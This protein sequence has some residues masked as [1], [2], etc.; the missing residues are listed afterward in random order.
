MNSKV[1]SAA[2]RWR[3]IRDQVLSASRAIEEEDALDEL[4]SHQQEVLRELTSS[5]SIDLSEVLEKLSI[6][7]EALTRP[8][9]GLELGHQEDVLVI[10]AL[11]DIRYLLD[12][13]TSQGAA[14]RVPQKI[15][16]S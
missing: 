9:G 7:Q 13:V 6:W 10:S 5:R 14:P 15:A 1:M 3:E 16:H 11:S 12:T 8:S 4:T 2:A